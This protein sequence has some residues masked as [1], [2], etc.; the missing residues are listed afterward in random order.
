VRWRADTVSVFDEASHRQTPVVSIK[1]ADP[2]SGIAHRYAWSQD[3][4]AGRETH[5]V[6]PSPEAERQDP[7]EEV[8]LHLLVVDVQGIVHKIDGVR[9]RVRLEPYQPAQ[10]AVVVVEGPL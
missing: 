8:L 7:E 2:A 1:E 6:P 3:S 10:V 5:R 9:L 4:Q